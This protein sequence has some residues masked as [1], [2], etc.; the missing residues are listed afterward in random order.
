MS[1][2]RLIALGKSAAERAESKNTL[3][4]TLLVLNVLLLC[5]TVPALAQTDSSTTGHKY[6]LCPGYYA[7]C[8]ASTCTPTNKTIVVRVTTGGTA[9]FPAVECTC[10]VFSGAGLGDLNG[11]NMQG[12]CTPPQA[13]SIWSLFSLQSEIAQQ[14]NN[15]VPTGPGAAAP[16]QVCPAGLGQGDQLSNCFSF[17]CNNEH[18]IN[19]VPVVTCTCPMGESFAGLPVDPDTAF[20]TQAGQG[21]LSFCFKHPVSVPIALPSLD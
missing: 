2:F 20:A 21:K 4:K 18:W 9:E 11:G 1:T 17:A 6:R 14:I 15:W 10:P 19:N 7:L 16:P 5:A 13:G 3:L 8:A 12:S